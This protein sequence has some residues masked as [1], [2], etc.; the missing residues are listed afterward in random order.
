MKI[1][2]ADP[3]Y[4]LV[5]QVVGGRLAPQLLEDGGPRGAIHARRSDPRDDNTLS[6][7]SSDDFGKEIGLILVVS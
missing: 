3:F 6:I 2:D 1:G 5:S 4:G 7:A